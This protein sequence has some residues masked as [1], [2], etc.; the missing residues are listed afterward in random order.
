MT[1]QHQREQTTIYRVLS[2]ITDPLSH[3]RHITAL[4]EACHIVVAVGLDGWVSRTV[5]IPREN[6]NPPHNPHRRGRNRTSAGFSFCNHRYR[7]EEALLVLVGWAFEKLYGDERLGLWDYQDAKDLLPNSNMSEYEAIAIKIV[8]QLDKYIISA[9]DMLMA[10][11][12]KKGVIP[13]TRVEKIVA[14]LLDEFDDDA[15]LFRQEVMR[16]CD[17]TRSQRYSRRVV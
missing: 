4:H 1:Q 10:S 15:W 16:F 6:G 8:T 5:G 7:E 2:G 14:K 17:K 3:H 13:V 9:A 11:A 12:N